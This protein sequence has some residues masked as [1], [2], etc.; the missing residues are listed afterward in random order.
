MKLNCTQGLAPSN[1]GLESS[2][3]KGDKNNMTSEE[4]LWAIDELLNNTNNVTDAM[5]ENMD[6]QN[7]LNWMD[8]LAQSNISRL[9]SNPMEKVQAL[10]NTLDI[11]DL[12]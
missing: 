12:I 8:N 11:T 9:M 6:P 10:L 1:K 7:P 5:D 3:Q 4:L 2:N